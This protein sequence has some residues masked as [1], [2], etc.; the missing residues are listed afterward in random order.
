[1]ERVAPGTDG[2]AGLRGRRYITP[3]ATHSRRGY[4]ARGRPPQCQDR[5]E[6][7]ASRWQEGIGGIPGA[8]DSAL[9]PL[10][11]PL[12][13]PSGFRLQDVMAGCPDVPTRCPCRHCPSPARSVSGGHSARCPE[14]WKDHLGAQGDGLGRWRQSFRPGGSA[15]RGPAIAGPRPN[16]FAHVAAAHGWDSRAR[17]H[18]VC[19]TCWTQS[20]SRRSLGRDRP[21]STP[22]RRW[23]SG[24]STPS[25]PPVECPQRVLR[26]LEPLPLGGIE[27]GAGPVDVEAEHGHRR[28]EGVRPSSRTALC[29]VPQGS[30]DG[31][32]V[33]P[34]EDPRLQVE[35]VAGARDPLGPASCVCHGATQGQGLNAPRGLRRGSLG[36]PGSTRTQ[37][38]S[39]R[40]RDHR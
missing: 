16:R 33:A 4:V 5:P 22:R 28:A 27:L 11:G 3:G 7:P 13:G 17:S 32:R 30:G 26:G 37:P 34:G 20:P 31:P 15:G 18:P 29:G 8:S 40:F 2:E 14:G 24:P 39:R 36:D 25:R 1:M 6:D 10:G 19:R 9:G 23:R 21:A 38:L 35:G 12:P